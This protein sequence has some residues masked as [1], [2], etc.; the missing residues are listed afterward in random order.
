MTRV[1]GTDTLLREVIM[2]NLICTLL[3]RVY[4]NRKELDQ[5]TFQNG[6]GVQKG[7]QEITKVISLVP[8]TKWQKIYEMYQVLLT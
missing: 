3:I 5:A 8:C 7:K 6:L 1:K 2:S 4:S